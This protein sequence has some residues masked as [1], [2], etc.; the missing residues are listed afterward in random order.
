M[1]I[2]YIL[3][4]GITT[5]SHNPKH[6]Q[7]GAISMHKETNLV[8]EIR[9]FSCK[10]NTYGPNSKASAPHSSRKL[11]IEA[12]CRDCIYDEKECGTWRQ[13]VESCTCYECPLFNYR[14]LTIKSIRN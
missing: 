2:K 11:A 10:R 8:S 4:A 6:N 13:Q 14:P 5:N 12:K 3:T 7:L 9:S 1:S